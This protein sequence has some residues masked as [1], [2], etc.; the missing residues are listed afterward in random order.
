MSDPVATNP[1]L[2]SVVFENDRVRVLEYLDAPGD[3]TQPH[4]HP[5]SV[6]VTLSAFSRRL[7]SGD[8]EVELDLPAFQ[9]RW[10]DAQEH[11]GMN[12]GETATHSIFVE[13]KEPAVS[14]GS[15]GALGPSD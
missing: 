12:V 5:D 1:E 9:A 14:A 8:R 4:H 2:Y 15:A 11:S 6:M 13:L 3:R 7:W 10:L